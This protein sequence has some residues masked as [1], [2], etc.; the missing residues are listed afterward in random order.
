[1]EVS[2][3]DAAWGPFKAYQSIDNMDVNNLELSEIQQ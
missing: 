1:M 3:V 2:E